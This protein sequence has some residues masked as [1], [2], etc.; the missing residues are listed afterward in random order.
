LFLFLFMFFLLLFLMFLMMLLCSLALR[1][2][3]L[4]LGLGEVFADDG[5]GG[6]VLV[7]DGPV[8]GSAAVV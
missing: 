3:S 2:I 5:L 1:G 6:G 4:E 7:L 8:Q